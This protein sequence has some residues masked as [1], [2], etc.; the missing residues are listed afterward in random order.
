MSQEYNQ[1]NVLQ[2][3]YMDTI[4]NIRQLQEME[5]QLFNTLE[6]NLNSSTTTGQG[7]ENYDD[8]VQRMNELSQ[9]RMTLFHQLRNSYGLTANDLQNSRNSLADQLAMVSMVENELNRTKANLDKMKT[10][11]T[12]QIRLVQLSTYE[13]ER[14]KA[15][16]GIMKIVVIA[17]VLILVVSLLTRRGLMTAGITT[18]LILLIVGIS[19]IVLMLRIYDL[20]RRN[21]FNYNKYDFDI[22][23]ADNISNTDASKAK[24][25]FNIMSLFKGGCDTL[26]HAKDQ[27][28]EK[29]AEQ[30]SSLSKN[31]LNEPNDK[32]RS[33]TTQNVVV[34][35]VTKNIE[36]L[37]N[38]R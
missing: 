31:A 3:R 12:N 16:I 18:S 17:S 32:V 8:I 24:S 28:Q 30:V 11:K 22:A 26:E 37:Q 4:N 29:I 14:Y 9:I 5:Q 2:E 10:N 7:S 20:S 33:P 23:G 1:S 19:F 36:M 34:P 27:L 6:T 38:Y 35:N 21:S 13:S 15:H 25:N